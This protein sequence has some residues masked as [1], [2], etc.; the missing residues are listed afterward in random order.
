MAIIKCP[1]CGQRISSIAKSCP[2]CAAAIQAMKP[3]DL[4]RLS[5]TRW[6]RQTERAVNATYIALAMLVGGAIWWW[7]APPQGWFFPPPVAT[8]VLVPIGLVIY[9][10]GRSWLF[11]LRLPR[12]RPPPE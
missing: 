4:A 9:L 12:N 5:R 7:G 10:L 2:H 3:E 8:L 6:R 11:W 1:A